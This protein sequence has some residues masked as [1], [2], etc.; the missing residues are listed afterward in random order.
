MK[1][2]ALCFLVLV[3]CAADVRAQTASTPLPV[4]RFALPPVIVT[5]DK[6]PT[7]AQGLPVS[8]TAVSGALV[9][10]AGITSISEASLFSPNTHFA[11]LSARKVSNPFIRGVGAS[12][13]NPAVTVYIDGVPQLNANSSNVELLDIEQIEFVRGPQSALFGRNTLAGVVNVATARPR[14]SGWTGSVEA[15]VGSA[16]ARAVRGSA[17]GPLSGRLAVGLSVGRSDR[18]GFTVN[19]VSG[20]ALDSRSATFGKAQALWVPADAW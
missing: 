10:S 7:D 17:S 13:S 1:L 4:N 8:V 6:V 14:L 18:N 20:H 12:P 19:D 9:E 5:A 2:Q 16:G 3:A 11:D 15:P